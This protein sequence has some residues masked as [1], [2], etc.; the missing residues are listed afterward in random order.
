MAAKKV[1]RPKKLTI[2]P[3]WLKLAAKL[4]EL[5]GDEFSNHG[6]N[7]WYFP[8]DWTKNERREFAERIREE[9]GEPDELE[10]LDDT[11]D[12]VDWEVMYFLA[13]VLKK[14]AKEMQG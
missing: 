11:L 3:K 2:N 1:Q 6:C 12:P 13:K 9:I 5:A 7:D 8:S 14:A 4:L 10:D